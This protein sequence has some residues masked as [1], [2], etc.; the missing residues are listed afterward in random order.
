MEQTVS[1]KKKKSKNSIKEKYLSFNLEDQIFALPAE[2]ILEIISMQ[3][4]TY[5]PNLPDYLK[6]VIN[7]RGK[8]MPLIDLRLRFGKNPKEYDDK[9]CIIMIENEE[10]TVGL[11]VDSVEDVLDIEM[12][13]L[14]PI[15]QIS[16]DSS[17]N[18]FAVSMCLINE[19]T[20]IILGASNIC[21]NEAAV[22]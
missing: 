9:T 7:V 21:M 5:M 1:L 10:I 20:I 2:Q 11:I 22:I 13:E 15:S 3:P 17:F 18:R 4:I 19:K 8:I 16:G 14:R 6:G 12:Q